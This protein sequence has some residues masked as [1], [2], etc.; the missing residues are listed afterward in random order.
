[1]YSPATK[2]E[3]MQAQE[4]MQ[5]ETRRIAVSSLLGKAD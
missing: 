5:D 2:V 3:A 4:L 1:V